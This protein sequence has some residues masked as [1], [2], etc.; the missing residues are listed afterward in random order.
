MTNTR[1][2]NL[3][4]YSHWEGFT[5]SWWKQLEDFGY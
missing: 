2:Q 3:L 5:T 1:H 4:N